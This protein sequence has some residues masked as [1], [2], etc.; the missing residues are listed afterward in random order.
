MR[1]V[2]VDDNHYENPEKINEQLFLFYKNLFSEK[3]END[4]VVLKEFFDNVNIPKLSPE[5]INVCEGHITEN[6]LLDALKSMDNN[7]S[8]GNNGLTKEFYVLFWSDIKKPFLASVRE[9]FLKE[10]L[11]ASQLQAIIK[12]IEKRD[13]DKRFIKNWRPI[14]LLNT[15]TKLISKA[16][17]A[18]VKQILPSLV[19]FNQTAYVEN[20]FIG[21]NGRLIP[22]ILEMTKKTKERSFYFNN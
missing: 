6:E 9:A 19:S 8:P 20:R 4:T 13:R 2:I 3:I 7:K 17:A 10:E 15:D 14:S 5:Q 16:L 1:S 18:R 22:D 11:S 21:Q 12:F